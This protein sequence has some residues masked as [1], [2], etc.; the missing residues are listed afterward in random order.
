MNFKSPIFLLR[1]ANSGGLHILFPL[2][3]SS[4]NTTFKDYTLSFF[5]GMYNCFN[6]STTCSQIK[7]HVFKIQWIL[8][9]LK[10]H[11]IQAKVTVFASI[12][13][14]TSN[15]NSWKAMI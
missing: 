7:W 13:N 15:I 12:A 6:A 10:S 8:L 4:G 9:R 1:F 11:I 14:T 5:V 2:S 3:S